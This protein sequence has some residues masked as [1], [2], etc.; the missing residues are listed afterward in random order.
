MKNHLSQFCVLSKKSMMKVFPRSLLSFI[1]LCWRLPNLLVSNILSAFRCANSFFSL[2]SYKCCILSFL[3]SCKRVSCY[4]F[5]STKSSYTII[6]SLF[7][8]RFISFC[9]YFLL[10][11]YYNK[12]FRG[13]FFSSLNDVITHCFFACN[14]TL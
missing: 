10:I 6:F 12:S 3:N 11:S 7:S 13:F 8:M 1:L 2:V 4:F 9:Y 5:S 14:M